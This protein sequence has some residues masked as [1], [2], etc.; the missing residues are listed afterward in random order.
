[1][2]K[3]N[4]TCKEKQQDTKGRNKINIC[5]FLKCF[6]HATLEKFTPSKQKQSQKKMLLRSAHYFL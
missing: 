6:H 1:M 4:L 3:K 2:Q 5:M